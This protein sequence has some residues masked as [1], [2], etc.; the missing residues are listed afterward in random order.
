MF[1]SRF[2]PYYNADGQVDGCKNITKGVSKWVN[3]I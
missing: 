3:Y 1:S 2:F